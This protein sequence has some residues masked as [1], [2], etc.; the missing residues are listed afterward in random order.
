M[1][2]NIPNRGCILH[3]HTV[4]GPFLYFPKKSFLGSVLIHSQALSQLLVS[5]IER[6]LTSE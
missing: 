1:F 2:P 6:G 4:D 5:F 3:L